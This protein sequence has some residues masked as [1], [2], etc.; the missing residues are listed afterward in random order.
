MCRGEKDGGDE[1]PKGAEKERRVVEKGRAE[2]IWGRKGG[3][4]GEKK[5]KRFK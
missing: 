2:T 5:K 1:N 4:G 3:G